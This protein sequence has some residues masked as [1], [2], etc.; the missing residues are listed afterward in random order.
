M[1]L[2]VFFDYWAGVCGLNW[3]HNPDVYTWI[4]F[5]F[6]TL[7]LLPASTILPLNFATVYLMTT[8]KN[9][10]MR[11]KPKVPPRPRFLMTPEFDYFMRQ[12]VF[13]P[14]LTPQEKKRYGF[15]NHFKTAIRPTLT[16]ART[17][18]QALQM[19]NELFTKV[20]EQASR[21]AAELPEMESEDHISQPDQENEIDSRTLLKSMMIVLLVFVIFTTP[22]ILVR[23]VKIALDDTEFSQHWITSLATLSQFAASVTNPLIYAWCREDFRNAFFRLGHCVCGSCVSEG[24]SGP[25]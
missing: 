17:S 13:S 19:R 10:G 24:T 20:E 16:E 4:M 6:V 23:I 5:S 15:L 1:F 9:P 14:D 2:Q 11:P 21:I 25:I 8:N 22:S 18:V 3:S 7:F 12:K